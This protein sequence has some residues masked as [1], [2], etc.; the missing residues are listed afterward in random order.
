MAQRSLSVKFAM[1]G[2][3]QLR[4]HSKSGVEKFVFLYAVYVDKY[5]ISFYAHIAVSQPLFDQ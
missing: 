2:S 3:D 4:I 1:S 5:N